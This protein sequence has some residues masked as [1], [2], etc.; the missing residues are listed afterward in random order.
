MNKNTTDQSNYFRIEIKS[1][2]QFKTF[3][4]HDVGEPGHILRLAGKK[5]DGS[6]DTQAWLIS[7]K[8]A[9]I[10]DNQLIP[11]TQD[12]KKL[13]E[14]LKSKPTFVKENVFQIKK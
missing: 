11:D 13:V 3:R 6:W 8:D 10:I 2:N 5:E 14:S 12:A 4:Y 7:K 9:H 1:K